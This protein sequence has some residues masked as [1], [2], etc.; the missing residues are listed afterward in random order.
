M[1][2]V[3]FAFNMKVPCGTFGLTGAKVVELAVRNACQPKTNSVTESRLEIAILELV[4][5]SCSSGLPL[6]GSQSA[7]TFSP[8]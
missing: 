2:T 3:T 8:M 5:Q 6:S 7:L 1:V 4:L